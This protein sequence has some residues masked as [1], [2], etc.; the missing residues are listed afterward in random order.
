MNTI[1]FTIDVADWFQVENFKPYIP[2]STWDRLDLR[3]E[4]NVHRILDLLDSV[5]ST[6]SPGA[7][8]IDRP[9]ATFFILGW[10]AERVPGMVRE[11]HDRGHEVASHGYD[12]DLCNCLTADALKKDL[13]E[14]KQLLEDIVGQPVVGY[15][16]PN[17]SVNN[18]I[19]NL[20][21]SCGYRYD[22]SYNSFEM[23][24]RY[25]RVELASQSPRL[26]CF[27]GYGIIST[28][29]GIWINSGICLPHSR[30]PDLYPAANTC[31]CDPK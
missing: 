3:V 2:Y 24:A 15:S 1:L 12:H 11:I 28:W 27:P 25:G 13:T 5:H 10:I 30:I 26:R 29:R 14:S 18:Q 31:V 21:E 4:R 9:R 7:G 16:A 23:N 8:C 22:A 6:C 17:F 19:L 20:I